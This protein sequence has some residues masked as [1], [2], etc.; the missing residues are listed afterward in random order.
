M[1]LEI[2][3]FMIA[4]EDT[5]Q[6]EIFEGEIQGIETLDDLVA[7]LERETA[8]SPHSKKEA[9]HVFQEGFLVVQSFFARELEVDS[10]QLMPE[11]EIVPLLKSLGKRRWIWE[12][13]RK[14][15]SRRIPPLC[16]KS[17][18]EWGGGLCVVVGFFLGLFVMIG[19]DNTVKSLVIRGIIGL[20]SGVL[21]GFFLFRLGLFLFSPLFSTI[22][23]GCRTLG[24]LA[25]C[26]VW[27]KVSLDPNGRLWS[28]ESIEKEVLQLVSKN[29]W[30]PVE[31][32]SLSKKIVDVF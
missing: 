12:K 4:V 13:L 17:Y 32:I 5:F 22:P 16:G 6:V 14:E 10:T 28:R 23:K 9:D 21:G 19:L 8:K 7:W 1:G 15:I 30:V 18:A 11:T 24:G 26:V 3:E 27:T 31:K 29:S 2:A 20:I 25:K